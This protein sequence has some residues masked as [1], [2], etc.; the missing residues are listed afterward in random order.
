M[1]RLSHTARFTLPIV[2]LSALA[3][4]CGKGPAYGSDNAVILVVHP[5][6]RDQVEPLVRA[7]IE[8]EVFTTRNERVFEI[9]ATTSSDIGEFRNWKRVIVVEPLNS[10]ILLPEIL[11]TSGDQVI[12]EELEDK[13]ARGQTIFVLAAPSQETTVDL[14]VDEIDGV[15]E[16]IHE[17]FVEAHVARMW[18]S[19]PDSVAFQQFFEEHGF[20]IV[21]PKV[22]RSATASAPPSS[23]VFYNEDPRRVISMHWLPRPASVSADDIL[24]VRRS[25]GGD[26]FEGDE[27]V[28]ETVSQDTV[29]AVAPEPL[30]GIQISETRVGGEPAIRLQGRWLNQEEVSGGV[31]VT[32]GVTCRDQLVLLDANLYAPDRDKYPYLI[33]FEEIFK[34]FTCAAS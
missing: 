20:G 19:E 29:E 7:A 1:R 25:W 5:D 28:A 21:L 13:W 34:T 18:A 2:I 31:F 23:V 26:L 16:V 24:E 32:Y 11:E 22:Y 30:P 6:L 33:Q 14:V 15:Y 8:R 12:V 10:P 9:T 4:G 27:I 17:R 3:A